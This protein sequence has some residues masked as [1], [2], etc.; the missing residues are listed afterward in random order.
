MRR[1]PGNPGVSMGS[2]KVGTD[3][4][5]RFDFQFPT[6]EP[7]ELGIAS[8]AGKESI[9]YTIGHSGESRRTATGDLR[10]SDAIFEGGSLV[11][12]G[13]SNQEKTLKPALRPAGTWN[14][15]DL[16]RIDDRLVCF[17]NGQ[18][19]N[20]V[21]EIRE[22]ND[23][24][25]TAPS[26]KTYHRIQCGKGEVLFRRIEKRYLSVF[27]PEL[28]RASSWQPLLDAKLSQWWQS[29]TGEIAAFEDNGSPAVRLRREPNKES[30][31]VSSKKSVKDHHLRLEFQFS[32]QGPGEFTSAMAW[33]NGKTGIQFHIYSDGKARPNAYS[34]RFEGAALEGSAIISTEIASKDVKFADAALQPPGAW[35]RFDLVRLDDRIACFVNG[36]LLGAVAGVRRVKDS[37]ESELGANMINLLCGRGTVS[38]RAVEVRDIVALPTEIT[39]APVPSK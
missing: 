15:L 19:L 32:P 18:F 38:M 2:R 7:A 21:A 6:Q 30:P 10:V 13:V 37:A 4:H 5:L 11:S 3:H 26:N 25:E 24:K 17:I 33:D 34:T 39:D 20:A 27:P 28:M 23:G 9:V 1:K 22:V 16:V 14:R 31:Y 29:T 36:R 12:T 35:N 8:S